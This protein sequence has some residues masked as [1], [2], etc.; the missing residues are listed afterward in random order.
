MPAA[1]KAH[2]YLHGDRQS[3]RQSRDFVF[4]N[5]S[6]GFY[7]RDGGCFLSANSLRLFDRNEGSQVALHT[8]SFLPDILSFISKQFW[9]L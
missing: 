2:G 6:L 3:Q 5:H 7:V 8:K 1:A 4:S 9:T